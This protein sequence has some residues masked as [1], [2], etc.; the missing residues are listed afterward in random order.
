MNIT[1]IKT[2][3]REI[4]YKTEG[5]KFKLSNDFLALITVISVITIAL[6]TMPSFHQYS[7]FFYII[8]II[9]TSIFTFEY[10]GRIIGT[11]HP[12]SYIFS[13]F[14]FIDL[15]A[16][17]PTLLG[18]GNLTFLK[19][20]RLLRVLRFLRIIKMVKV[21][22]YHKSKSQNNPITEENV[23]AKINFEIYIVALII[24]L[25]FSAISM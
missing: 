14:G 19:A 16:I 5:K 4:F 15:I 20:A 1:R 3:F 11:K 17:L 8:E 22:E 18:I 25:F 23:F 6:E 7:Y 24:S 21:V 2:F 12:K 13:F 10:L 9:S